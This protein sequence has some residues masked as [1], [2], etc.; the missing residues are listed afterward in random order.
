MPNEIVYIFLKMWYNKSLRKMLL[1]AIAEK[2]TLNKCIF[3]VL[4]KIKLEKME[5]I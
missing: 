3:F 5:I 1:Y 2:N 4:W